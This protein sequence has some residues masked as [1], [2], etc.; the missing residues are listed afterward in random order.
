M[1]TQKQRDLDYFNSQ[2]K[3]AEYVGDNAVDLDK[4]TDFLNDLFFCSLPQAQVDAVIKHLAK[5]SGFPK[6]ALEG[7]YNNA[8]K[9]GLIVMKKNAYG[10][11]YA[12]ETPDGFNSVL[13]FIQRSGKVRVTGS[14]KSHILRSEFYRLYRDWNPRLKPLGKT[15]VYQHINTRLFYDMKIYYGVDANGR[16]VIRGVELVDD[17]EL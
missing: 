1:I 5:A 13:S 16:D 7:Q 6:R 14:K 2:I 15:V 9:A 12:P 10:A 8:V 11:E 17:D 3:R 4:V